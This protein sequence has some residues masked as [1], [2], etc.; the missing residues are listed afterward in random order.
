[1]S[2][3]ENTHP[4]IRIHQAWSREKK[5]RAPRGVF[6]HPSGVWA[7]RFTCGAGHVHQER[8]GP[9]KGDAVRVYHDR[10]A[11]A[12]DEPGRCPAVERQQERDRAAAEREAAQPLTF[13]QYAERWHDHTIRPHRKDRTAEYYRGILDLH[14]VPTFGASPLADVTGT[15]VRVFIADKLTGLPCPNHKT[16]AADC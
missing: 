6:R 7:A 9:L 11:R 3:P 13:G 12:M 8:V 10:R 15:G 5:D 4:I 14:L 2:Q 1:M 16:V